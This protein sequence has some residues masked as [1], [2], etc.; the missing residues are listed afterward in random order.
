[1]EALIVYQ[2]GAFSLQGSRVFS[3]F[4]VCWLLICTTVMAE[5]AQPSATG[6]GL[7]RDSIIFYNYPLAFNPAKAKLA[8]E[9]KGIKYTEKKIDLFNGQSLEPWYLKLNPAASSPTLVVGDEK[10]VESADIIR[11]A[12]SQGAPL[13]GD[14]VDRAFVKEWLEKVD[15]WDGNLFAAANS[16]SSGAIKFGTKHKIKVAEAN[17]KR[18]PDM[19]ELYKKKIATMEAQ[20]AEP[21]NREAVEQN[22]RQLAG[23]LDEAEARLSTNKFLAG[24][25]YSAADCIFTPVIYRLFMVKKDKEFLE[26]R[27]NIQ[28]Y[29]DELKKRPSYKKVF[30]VADSGFCTAQTILPAFGKILLQKVTGKY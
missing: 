28:R 26:P 11:W 3:N 27:P 18:N 13:G 15:A 9:E 23:L 25:S 12:D 8:L 14:S 2:E 7:A 1:M 17:M 30:G 21:D 24:D 22:L 6:V 16:S 10:I 29:Y 5:T 4:V 20:L 19:A